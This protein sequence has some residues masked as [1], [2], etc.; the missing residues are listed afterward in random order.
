MNKTKLLSVFI[1][2]LF[3]KFIWFDLIWCLDTTFKS[4]S[5]PQTYLVK[6]ML[7]SLLA[8]PLVFIRSK[9]YAVITGSLLDLLLIAN[10]MYFRTYYT[11]IP[12]DSYLL[13]SNLS[14]F[15]SSVLASFRWIDLGFPML[16]ILFL[17]LTRNHSLFIFKTG[18]RKTLIFLG[19]CILIPFLI[20]GGIVLI[21]GGYKK[22]YDSLLVHS[23]TCGTPMYTIF[24]TLY[25]EHVRDKQ[26][27]TP[28][29]KKEID[30]FLASRPLHKPLPFEVEE[31]NN[32]IIILAESFESW[33]LEREVEGK[34]ITPRLNR[35]LKEPNVLYAPY[36]QTQ[37]RGGRS[38]DA[39]LMLNTGL[40]PLTFGVYSARFPHN[41]Y[42]SLEKALRQK[43]PC[44]KASCFTVDKKVVWN[45]AV[46]ARSFG[47]DLLLDKPFWVLDEKTGPMHKLGDASFLRQCAEKM[48]SEQIIPTDG[49]SLVQCVTYSGH[50]PFIIPD[51]L[52]RISFTMDM[53]K[54]LNDYLTI[55]NYTDDA[56]GT[57]I[58]LLRSQEKFAKTMIVITGD[59][60]GLAESRSH[61]CNSD[62]GKGMVATDKFTPFIVINSPVELRYEE[63]MG[64]IDMYPTLLNLLGLDDYFWTGMG[65]S[66]LDPDKKKF[67]ISFS[68]EVIGNTEGVSAQEI[69]FA[70]KAWDIS[71]RMI[72][73]DYFAR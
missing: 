28:E 66:I 60:E 11:A 71:D 61:L 65:Q 2:C 16:T 47:F 33:V 1:I 6:F 67:A 44:G 24:G 46:V 40:L 4:F 32:C 14:G 48:A 57:F 19:K 63:V 70:R 72:S 73:C 17:I 42:P 27:Y 37:V 25:Y 3:L 69:E 22:A 7:A 10:L 62:A 38:I 8:V 5:Y 52:K 23:Q 49:H 51:E 43:Y 53:P 20:T 58:D 54:M 56:I 13:I 29:V 41:Y 36:M 68:Q 15:T 12:S 64:Q 31:R 35:L 45:Q 21:S 26:D 39:Q 30:D 50:H 18:K 34:E 55:A 59:H 9:W